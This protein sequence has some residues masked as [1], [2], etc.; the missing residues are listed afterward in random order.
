MGQFER[1]GDRVQRER[2]SHSEWEQGPIE[3]IGGKDMEGRCCPAVFLDLMKRGGPDQPPQRCRHDSQRD[4]FCQLCR[5]CNL[6]KLL[7]KAYAEAEAQ[8][9]L[10]AQQ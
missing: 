7:L 5:T 9:H 10:A 6:I 8:E 4:Y 1:S 2:Q 3:N